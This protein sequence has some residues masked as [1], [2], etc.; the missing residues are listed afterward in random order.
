MST[1][2]TH[3]QAAGLAGRVF[4]ERQLASLLG[5]SEARR[6]GLVNRAIKDGSLIR[7]KRATYMLSSTITGSAL[8]PFA[9][10]QALLPGSYISF[11]TALAHH[12]WIPEAVYVNASVTPYRKSIS[13]AL[14][15]NGTFTYHPLALCDYQFL[16]G[17]ERAKLGSLTAFVASPLRALSDLIALNK[18]SWQ[19]LEWLTDGMRIDQTCL[20]ALRRKDFA[21]LRPVYKHKTA[22]AFLKE[23][24]STLMDLKAAHD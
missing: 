1:L 9:V 8:H 3:I 21:A 17:V 24:E 18:V 6:Y 11:E 5:G 16:Q 4:N 23:L 10:A 14:G 12:G 13:Y 7:L 2:V 22:N 19:G 15:G 20:L